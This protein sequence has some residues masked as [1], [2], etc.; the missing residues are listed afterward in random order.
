MP[1]GAGASVD[2]EG[3]ISWII[4]VGEEVEVDFFEGRRLLG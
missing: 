4:G 3:V 1:A 2:E